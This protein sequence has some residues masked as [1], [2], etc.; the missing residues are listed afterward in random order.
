MS[1]SS[2]LAT[3]PQKSILLGINYVINFKYTFFEHFFP[4]F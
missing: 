1:H 3:M 2:T 4:I